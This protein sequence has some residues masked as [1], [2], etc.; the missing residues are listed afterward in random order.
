MLLKDQ[1]LKNQTVGVKHWLLGEIYVLN[2]FLAEI[3]L[4]VFLMFP[5]PGSSLNMRNNLRIFDK[6][7]NR[8]RIPLTGLEDVD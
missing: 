6:N 7:Q 8:F 5:T 4:I 3:I 1:F 2:N